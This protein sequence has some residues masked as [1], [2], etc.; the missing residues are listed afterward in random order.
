LI[1]IFSEESD[2]V[3]Q[4]GI[5]VTEVDHKMEDAEITEC[6]EVAE[7]IE[8]HQEDN[9]ITILPSSP[10]TMYDAE[11]KPETDQFSESVTLTEEPSEPIPEK[12]DIAQSE[13][14]NEDSAVNVDPVVSSKVYD[15]NI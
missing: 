5:Q 6:H 15:I 9:S 11:A 10:P 1:V 7:E 3:G 13:D 2:L 14:H 4:P 8:E 12:S